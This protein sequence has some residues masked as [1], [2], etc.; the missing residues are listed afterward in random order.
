M[1]ITKDHVPPTNYLVVRLCS[2]C[3]QK[4]PEACVA[5]PMPVPFN[6]M[7]VAK[8]FL[9]GYIQSIMD[10]EQENESWNHSTNTSSLTDEDGEMHNYSYG[11]IQVSAD[12]MYNFGDDQKI[13]N[14]FDD[15]VKGLFP[16]GDSK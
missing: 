8:G 2:E 4:N 13:A 10:G 12:V 6:S 16:D 7:N 1:L 5:A 3:M 11:I 14:Q 15:I 9:Q